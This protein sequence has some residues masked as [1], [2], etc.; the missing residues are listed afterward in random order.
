MRALLALLLMV[1]ALG[2]ASAQERTDAPASI[3]LPEVASR[4]GGHKLLVVVTVASETHADWGED[5][6]RVFREL[7]DGICLV[8]SSRFT[9][10]ESVRGSGALSP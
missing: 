2:V 8:I 10:G 5:Y 9:A 6:V 3:P 1:V 7:G 4:A